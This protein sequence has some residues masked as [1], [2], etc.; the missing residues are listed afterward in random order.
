MVSLITI[1]CGHY[2]YTSLVNIIQPTNY[3]GD[4]L[5]FFINKIMVEPNI[6]L[7]TYDTFL[8]Y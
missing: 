3:M 7:R 8:Y 1:I 2:S 6:I 4:Q 5:K